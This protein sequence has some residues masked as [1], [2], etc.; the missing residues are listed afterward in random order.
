MLSLCC[1]DADCLV[2]LAVTVMHIA[3]RVFALPKF[4]R[5]RRGG[6]TSRLRYGPRQAD[7]DFAVFFSTVA[8]G[9]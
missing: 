3:E 7:D 9:R 8:D 6:L 5:K 1:V 2:E 4:G